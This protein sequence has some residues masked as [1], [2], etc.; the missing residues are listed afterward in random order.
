MKFDY[1]Y[2]M[3]DKYLNLKADN[4]ARIILGICYNKYI[5]NN[6]ANKEIHNGKF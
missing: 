1:P 5:P 3:I 6:L 2:Y 4:N